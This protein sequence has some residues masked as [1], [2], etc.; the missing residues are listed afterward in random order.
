MILPDLKQ[1]YQVVNYHQNQRDREPGESVGVFVTVPR[2]L[3]DQFPVKPGN[4]MSPAH[5]TVLFCGDLPEMFEEKLVEIVRQICEQ[6]KPFTVSLKDP[7]EFVNHKGETII[8][9]PIKSKKLHAFRDMIKGALL[10]N[11]IPVD[12][13]HPEYK[14]HVTIRYLNPG[15]ENTYNDPP[16][17]GEWLVDHCW[18]WGGR[19]PVLIYLGK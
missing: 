3:A 12:N 19:E 16:P 11:Q 1:I 2:H 6:A 7:D 8:H 17:E 15:E 10:L 4:D 14:P 5:I 13:K 18:V 9:S